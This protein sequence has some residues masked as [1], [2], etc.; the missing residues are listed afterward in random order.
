MQAYSKIF[1]YSICN[2]P[3]QHEIWP[4][5]G[6]LNH[7]SLYGIPKISLFQQIIRYYSPESVRYL[8]YNSSI[9]FS[10]PFN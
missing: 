4:A 9:A 8:V 5:I 7:L 2:I 10:I 6:Y 3:Y 1:H